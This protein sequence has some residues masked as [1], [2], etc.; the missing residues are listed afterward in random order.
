MSWANKFVGIPQQDLGRTRDG[1]DCWGLASII[2]REELGMTLPD[3]L[4]YSSPDDFKEVSELIE[5]VQSTPLWVPQS[6]PAI[7]FD[8][9][10][11]RRGHLSTHVG[12][13]VRHGLMIH[14]SA[15]DQ[16]LVETYATGR[17]KNRFAGHFRHRDRTHLTA[18][19]SPVE[20]PVQIISEVSR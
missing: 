7:A 1:A 10:V 4:N 18:S 13:V 5:G 14:M 11:F 19:K 6:G 9:A 15:H 8:I 12:I 3:Y 20:R 2:Y 16:S 17:W